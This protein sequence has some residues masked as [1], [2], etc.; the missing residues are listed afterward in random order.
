FLLGH[1]IGEVVAA[2]VSGVFSLEDACRLVVA[3]GRLMQAAPDGGAMV[4]LE[5]TEDEV[6]AT[7]PP[8]VSIAG[9]NGP[10]SVV[11]SGDADAVVR[12]EQQWRAQSRRTKRLI[13][14]HAFHSAHMDGVLDEFRAVVAGLS[15]GAARIPVV[16]NVTGVIATD[17]QLGSPDYWARH[18]R[19][20]VRFYDG[21]KHL[22]GAGVSRFVELGPDGVLSALTGGA[23]LLRAGRSEVDQFSSVVAQL[24]TT[25]VRVDWSPLLAGGRRV[26][27]PTYAFQRSRYWLDSA[28]K[29]QVASPGSVA[30]GHP[31]VSAAVPVAGSGEV[32]LSGRL[33]LT[34]QPWLAEHRV[35]DLIVVPAAAL[36]EAVIRAGDE[37]GCTLIRDLVLTA[38]L[39]L[40]D[41]QA[42]TLQI[43]VG[44]DDGNGERQ[45]WVH[46]RPE[47]ATPAAWTHCADAHI[48]ADTTIVPEVPADAVTADVALAEDRHAE[49][50]RYGLHP[51]LLSAATLAVTD[52]AAAPGQVRV[53]FAW[54]GVRLLAAGATAVRV[55][56]ATVDDDTVSL[57]LL[58]GTGHPVAV[59]DAVVFG[60][61]PLAA[62]QQA[63]DGPLVEQVAVP[64]RAAART[65]PV[66]T[67]AQRIGSLPGPERRKT[68]L[69]LVRAEV[70]GVLGHTDPA[71]VLLDRSFQDLGFDSLA[72]VNLRNQ[73]GTVTGMRITATAVFDH[74]TP[75]ALAEHL[76]TLAAPAVVH[77]SPLVEL[78]RLETVLARVG[79]DDHERAQ[80]TARLQAIATRWQ[81]QPDQDLG[82]DIGSASAAEIFDFIDNEL[83]RTAN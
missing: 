30:T 69:D 35:E 16:S 82:R 53:P 4:A 24:H 1:S 58:D 43:R 66:Q 18:I 57:H 81:D 63:Q 65:A 3:R 49:A 26:G 34:R 5:A 31:L 46:A 56:S 55:V 70:A 13:V 54:H 36:V 33:S 51:L 61:L 17:E 71:A 19:E 68:V 11:V 79:H 22:E 44:A 48:S 72:A 62:F 76:L 28:G 42:L 23:P 77:E 29:P 40:P 38:P 21:V 14:S 75:A 59:A 47:S 73:L 74:P 78:D 83:G 50:A 39:V 80:I 20:A 45:V 27:L 15:F 2:H 12:V 67:L 60:D 41:Q 8:G 25:G 7:L 6:V 37:V 9:V 32:L 64:V 10:Q 52:S